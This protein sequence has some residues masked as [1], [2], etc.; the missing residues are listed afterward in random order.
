MA[1]VVSSEPAREFDARMRRVGIYAI[2]GCLF[3][4]LAKSAIG[5]FE[6]L[7]VIFATEMFDW[8]EMQ[9]GTS[10]SM[11]GA[12]SIVL[13]LCFPFFLRACSDMDLVIFGFLFMIAANLMLDAYFIPYAINE[14]RFLVAILL[15]FGIGYPVCN[16]AL[17]GVFSNL[18][19]VGADG[20]MGVFSA[21]GS[22]GRIIAPVFAGAATEKY[23][24]SVVFTTIGLVLAGGTLVAIVGRG[25]VVRDLN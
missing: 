18:L 24:A 23:G 16:T 4:F 3:Q 25:K 15:M 8:N 5:T 13:L 21:F 22:L 17:V 19:S 2:I 12:I 9:T 1:R 7:L 10:I 11:G 6:T 14:L 20:S